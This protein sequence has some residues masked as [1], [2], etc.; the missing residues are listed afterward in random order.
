MCRAQVAPGFKLGGPTAVVTVHAPAPFCVARSCCGR[1]QG[2]WS[3]HACAHRHA[4]CFVGGSDAQQRA[5]VVFTA[6][7]ANVGHRLHAGAG[8]APCAPRQQGLQP[9]VAATSTGG[10]CAYG[11]PVLSIRM[12]VCVGTAVC[13]R[14]GT[15]Y[16][17][18]GRT[19]TRY[20]RYVKSWSMESGA[21]L[22]CKS[23]CA[24]KGNGTVAQGQ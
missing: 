5:S 19:G 23:R 22:S 4:G 24:G 20:R 15:V 7:Y 12:Y 3:W 18:H 8:R 21:E 1:T 6:W 16:G 17:M 2:A 9:R 11:H 13:K 10:G 14:Y